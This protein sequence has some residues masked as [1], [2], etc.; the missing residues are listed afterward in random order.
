MKNKIT[1][2]GSGSWGK[3]LAQLFGA[4]EIVAGRS[5][6]TIINAQYVFLAVEAQKYREVLAKHKFSPDSIIIICS[7]GIEQKTLCL[8]HEVL[9][10]T[11]PNKYAVLSGP[12]FAE[13]IAKGLPAVATVAS[14]DAAVREALSRDLA[15][16]NF[17]IY[18][19]DDVASVEICGAVKNVMAIAAGVCV[20]RGLGENAKAA[21][22]TRGLAELA[23][24]SAAKGGKLETLFT[25]AGVGDL[26]LTAGSTKSRNFEFGYNIGKE[27]K[28]DPNN[29]NEARGVIEGY[30]T[31][32]SLYELAQKLGVEMPIC[33]TAYEILYKNKKV[34]EAI[35]DLLKRPQI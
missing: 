14:K 9:E 13:E 7:K 23:R 6:P 27:G 1:V 21:L 17:R 15:R 31:A 5:E 33:I 32:N 2:V 11:V 28:F 24:L 22:V 35:N 25:P 12:N 16:P 26:I 4:D 10:Q 19:S 3:A 18:T 30:Y 34:D 29:I 8:M 20:G